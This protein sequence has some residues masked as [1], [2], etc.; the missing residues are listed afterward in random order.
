[1]VVIFAKVATILLVVR[2][3]ATYMFPAVTKFTNCEPTLSVVMFAVCCTLKFPVKNT[4]VVVKELATAKFVRSP[5]LVMFGWAACETTRATLA[6]ATLPTRFEEL[7]EY[8]AAP[9]AYTFETETYGG[10]SALTRA[11]NKG[12]PAEPIEGPAK[13][14][15]GGAPVAVPVP[16]DEMAKGVPKVSWS[17]EAP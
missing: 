17:I 14:W 5:T 15:F 7:R 6:F 16:P 10:K 13:T 4:F 9:F 3:F 11:R 2:E 12:G 8:R 1:M